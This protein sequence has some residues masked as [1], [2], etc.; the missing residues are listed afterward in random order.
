[1]L[2]FLL[3]SLLT[4]A[5]LAGAGYSHYRYRVRNDAIYRSRFEKLAEAAL[6]RQHPSQADH[7]R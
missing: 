4:V 2:L 5:A 7:P 6:A 3:W 1:M